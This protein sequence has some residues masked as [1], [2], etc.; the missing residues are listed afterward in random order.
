MRPCLPRLGKAIVGL[1]TVALVVTGCGQDTATDNGSASGKIKVVASTNVWGSVAQA[2]GG[3]AVEVTSILSDP[4]ADPH[5][6]EGKPA[7]TAAMGEARL[8]L[9]NGGGYDDFFTTSLDASGTKASRIE[10][11]QV[12]GKEPG[13]NE[14]VWYDLPTVRKV[15]DQLA[16]DLGTIAPD[17][18]DLF[19]GNAR[20]FNA[21]IDELIGKVEQAGKAKPGAAVVATEPVADYLVE[22]AGL[23]NATPAEFA[24]AIEEETDPSVAAVAETTDLIT[25]KQA[26]ALINNAQTEIPATKQLTLTAAAAGVPVVPVTETLP[27][28]VSGY[29]DWMSKQVDDLA[30]ALK[31]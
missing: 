22:L 31:G 19:A 8:V 11:Y 6:Y 28:G 5:S 15:A 7:D 9:Y 10:A 26:V 25:G 30:G 17:R 12:S 18:K 3:D 24:E 21:G 20:T 1:A 4:S 13:A 2:V 27:E 23:K 29:L 14:H 16:Q